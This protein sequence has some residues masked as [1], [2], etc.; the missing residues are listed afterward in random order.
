[1]RTGKGKEREGCGSQREVRREKKK[2]EKKR[3]GLNEPFTS[4][5]DIGRRGTHVSLIGI[6]SLALKR[7]TALDQNRT[8]RKTKSEGAY[9]IHFNNNFF[10]VRSW[11]RSGSRRSRRSSFGRG[12]G[13]H[14]GG[15]GERSGDR[16]N[17]GFT[18]VSFF[19]PLK[20]ATKRKIKSKANH[21]YRERVLRSEQRRVG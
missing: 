21:K 2:E 19:K 20:S 10:V 5:R 14:R 4:M 16:N 6:D 9:I 11:R 13:S 1:L 17:T 15:Q 7:Q 8:K 12:R 18:H 3:E